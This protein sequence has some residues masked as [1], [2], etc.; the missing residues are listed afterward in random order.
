[1]SM[2][3]IAAQQRQNEVEATLFF[4]ALLSFYSH[5]G[6]SFVHAGKTAAD[7]WEEFCNKLC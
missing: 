5:H 4:V 1:M 2:Q 3:V 6:N 7:A